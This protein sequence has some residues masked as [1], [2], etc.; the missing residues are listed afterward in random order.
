MGLRIP[1][2]GIGKTQSFEGDRLGR[3]GGAG[4]SQPGSA[5]VVDGFDVVSIGVKDERTVIAL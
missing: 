3:S 2:A 4:L 1:V 5:S